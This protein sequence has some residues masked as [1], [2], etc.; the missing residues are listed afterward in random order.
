[1]FYWTFGTTLSLSQHQTLQLSQSF[2][3]YKQAKR[4]AET[5][6]KKIEN[7]SKRK[8]I[9]DLSNCNFDKENCIHEVNSYT[10]NDEVNFSA[11]GR[12]CNFRNS[13]GICK[14]KMEIKMNHTRSWSDLC[15]LTTNKA[16]QNNC[17][18]M[19]PTTP[20]SYFI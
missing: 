3:S 7:G 2:E 20:S 4:R 10:E 13:N 1:M 18:F 14:M 16:I 11:L 12:K 6:Q 5:T 8:K 9:R 17:F 15:L 19:D